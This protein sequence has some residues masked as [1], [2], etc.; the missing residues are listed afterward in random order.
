MR[1][2]HTATSANRFN[3][4]ALDAVIMSPVACEARVIFDPSFDA[5]VFDVV[6]NVIVVSA[7]PASFVAVV[8][9]SYLKFHE[10]AVVQDV[11][12]QVRRHEAPE[13]IVTMLFAHEELMS[14]VFVL[15]F[16]K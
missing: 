12:I 8:S 5:R 15:L 13:A 11:S 1:T 4:V 3:A 16:V 9:P 7:V 14:I 2:L 6:G 10:A